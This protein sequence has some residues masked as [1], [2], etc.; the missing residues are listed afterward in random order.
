MRYVKANSID[1]A[2]GESLV[3]IKRT[4]SIHQR[5]SMGQEVW[6]PPLYLTRCHGFLDPD[7]ALYNYRV[8]VLAITM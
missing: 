8:L 5:P 4:T 2:F 6:T 3:K 7:N 1:L